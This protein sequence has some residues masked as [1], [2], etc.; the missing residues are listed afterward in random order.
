MDEYFLI[1]R[2]WE[3]SAGSFI[4]YLTSPNIITNVLKYLGAAECNKDSNL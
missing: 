4:L 3:T 2:L 1:D